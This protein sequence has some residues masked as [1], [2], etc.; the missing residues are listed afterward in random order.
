MRKE[1]NKMHAFHEINPQQIT[2]NP[3]TLIGNDWMLI[4]AQKPDGTFNTM[5]ASWGGV[6]IMWGKPVAICMIRPQRYTFEFIESAPHFT[7][8]FFNETWR[9]AL[10]LCGSKSGR[11]TDKV[12]QTGITPIQQNGMVWFEQAKLVLQCR[13]LYKNDLSETHFLDKTLLDT[14]QAGDYHRVYISAI[15]KVLCR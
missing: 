1:W 10:R 7:L 14:Y 2:E 8:S 11:D 13:Q 9:D 15:E 4:T 5:T 3:F 6:G 12:A